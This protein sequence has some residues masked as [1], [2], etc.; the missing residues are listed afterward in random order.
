MPYLT[1]EVRAARESARREFSVRL[2]AAMHAAGMS[3]GEL[4]ER[5]GILQPNLSAMILGGHLKSGQRPTLQ[6][7]P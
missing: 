3:Q 1:P 7:R 2:L 4:A 5:A 6:N